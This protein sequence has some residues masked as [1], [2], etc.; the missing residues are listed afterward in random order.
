MCQAASSPALNAVTK[1][2]AKVCSFLSLCMEVQP[3]LLLWEVALPWL[4]HSPT[5]SEMGLGSG[6]L[7]LLE[8]CGL[9]ACSA[10]LPQGGREGSMWQWIHNLWEERKQVELYLFTAVEQVAGWKQPI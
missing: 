9:Q 10:A 2:W 4:L 1:P 5:S 7:G 8:Q 6:W 3:L